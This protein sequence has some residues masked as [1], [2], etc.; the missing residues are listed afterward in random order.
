MTEVPVIT[1]PSAVLT[2]GEILING[3]PRRRVRGTDVYVH[4]VALGGSTFGWT[5][6]SQGTQEILDRYTASGGNFVSVS[7]H[8]ASG[9]SEVMLGSW[10][11]QNGN[12]DDLVI[13]TTAGRAPEFADGRASS[14]IAATEASLTRLGVE[15]IDLL[16]L[17]G[18]DDN[19]RIEEALAAGDAL[20]RSGKV[21]HLIANDYSADRLLASRINAAALGAPQF[22]AVSASY[23]L[24][25]RRTF[26]TQI[27]PVAGVQ[28][29]SVIPKHA[30]AGGFLTGKFR[31][32]E[33]AGGSARGA[34]S[35]RFM[36]R[37][38]FRAL[39]ALESVAAEQER[40]LSTIALAW[41]LTKR[42]VLAPEVSAASPEHVA[43]IIGAATVQLSRHQVALLDAAS[44]FSR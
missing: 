33:D 31:T 17:Y 12:R 35:A 27:A 15:H 26:E 10:I 38:G 43:G 7:D 44:A 25:E 28:N 8:Y 6:D 29:L 20:I 36:N 24:V 9:R 39:Q 11:R 42:Q 41:L 22:V 30:L 21:R 1:A 4:P 3:F 32:K 16:G 13:A 2:T 14:I 34:A 5:A 23:N 40:P 18:M 19:V 37:S